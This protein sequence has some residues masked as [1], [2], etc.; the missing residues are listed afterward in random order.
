MA[1]QSSAVAPQSSAKL[2]GVQKSLLGLGE[3]QWGSVKLNGAQWNSMKL[4]GGSTELNEAQWGSLG[5]RRGH[6]LGFGEIQCIGFPVGISEAQWT[7]V[8]LNEPQ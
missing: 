1:P 5:F 3:A 6:W 7:S 4:S 2:S 8:K